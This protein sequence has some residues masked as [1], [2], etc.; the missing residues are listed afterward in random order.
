[1][2][3]RDE[4]L[5]DLFFVEPAAAGDPTE[6]GQ[7]R[8]NAAANDIVAYIDGQVKSLTASGA[9]LLGKAIVTSDGGIVYDGDGDLLIKVSE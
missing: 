2:G 9:S 1:M 8:L 6:E 3:V 7:V 4:R 5:I